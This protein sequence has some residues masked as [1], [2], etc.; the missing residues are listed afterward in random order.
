MEL[1]TQTQECY[2]DKE[3]LIYMVSPELLPVSW[4]K[5]N[6]PVEQGKREDCDRDRFSSPCIL[7]YPVPMNDGA[8]LD[9]QLFILVIVIDP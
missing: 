4:H 5:Q 8:F 1:S 9:V 6:H 7:T 2:P 3:V